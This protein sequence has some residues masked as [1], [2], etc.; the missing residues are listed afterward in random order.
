MA[1]FAS[2]DAIINALTVSGQKDEQWFTKIAPAA[3]EAA[4]VWQSLWKG[5]GIPGAGSDPAATPGTVYDSDATTPVAGSVWFPDR[6]PSTRF[7]TAFGAV[8]SQACTLLLYDRLAGVSGISLATTGNKTVN[9]GALTRYSGAAADDNEVWLE[10]T[11]ATT[12]TAPVVSLNSY[13]SADGSTAQS[14]GTVTFPAA[15]TDLHTMVKMP[16]SAT[17]KGVRSVEA[18]LNVGT[19]AAAGA[20]NVLITK[21]IAYLPLAANVYNEISFLDDNLGLPQ[22]FD[23]ATLG[24]ALLA[25]VTT[26]VT[27]SGKIQCAWG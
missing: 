26:A 10:V 6:S 4:G 12:T 8:A 7:L 18:G 23:N 3:A 15:A 22:I 11:T 14:G 9:S 13:T 5:T 16:L 25:T 20:V 19:A 17:K 1:G 24:I 21:P 27:V 2:R